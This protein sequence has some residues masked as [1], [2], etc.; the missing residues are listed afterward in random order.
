MSTSSRWMKTEY[1]MASWHCKTVNP[2]QYCHN[3]FFGKLTVFAGRSV[4]FVCF[5]GG[6]EPYTVQGHLL[7]TWT[8]FRDWDGCAAGRGAPPGESNARLAH[9]ARPRTDVD[10]LIRAAWSER[11]MSTSSWSRWSGICRLFSPCDSRTLPVVWSAY[12]QIYGFSSITDAIE[13]MPVVPSVHPLHFRWCS[14]VCMYT[15]PSERD[16]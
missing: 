13:L 15:E 14:S 11:Q 2:L 5:S 7:W 6:R 3:V 8:S 12:K 9:N 10:V 16:L 4:I 1:W